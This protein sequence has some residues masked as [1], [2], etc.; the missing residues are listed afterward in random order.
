MME[1]YYRVNYGD[2]MIAGANVEVSNRLTLVRRPGNPNY[3]ANSW[4][5][6]LSFDEFRVNKSASDI[7]GTTLEE[8][9]TMVTE[10]GQLY[11]LTSGLVKALV[12]DD[13]SMVSGQTYMQEVGNSLYFANGVDN[14]KWIQSLFQRV[15]GNNN[16]YPQGS[17]GLAGTYPFGTF[18]IDSNNNIEEM[19]GVAAATITNIAITSKVLTVTL[20]MASPNADTVDYVKGTSFMLW[21]VGTQTWLNG[22]IVTS[23]NSYTHGAGTWTFTAA[24]SHADVVSAVETGWA[25]QIGTTPV[26]A[27]TG[28][29]PTFHT[30]VSNASNNSGAIAPTGNITLDGNILWM[31]RGGQVENW[32]IQAPRTA[33]TVS[34]T[35]ASS[36]GWKASTYYSAPGVIV[37]ANNNIWQ[38]TT[39]GTTG[40]SNTFPA[41]PTVGNTHTDG[42]AVWTCVTTHTSSGQVW[43]AHT[44]Y[45][46]GTY[47]GAYPWPT[48]TPEDGAFLPDWK[49]GK[50]IIATASGTP[51][52]FMLQKNIPTSNINVPISATYGGGTAGHPGWTCQF[53]T[54]SNSVPGGVIDLDY[55][56][57]GTPVR[58]GTLT[59]ETPTTSATG[60]TSLLWDYYNASDIATGPMK[61][62]TLNSAGE[63]NASTH[64]TPWAGMPAPSGGGYTFAQ[65]GKI[66][67]QVD[68]INVTFNILADSSCYF[69][70]EAA[71]G[72]SIVSTSASP[73]GA[74]PVTIESAPA[75]GGSLGTRTLTFWNGYPILAGYNTGNE[76]GS[77]MSITV[78]FPTAG[79]YA[80]EFDF[81]S[82]NETHPR[83]YFMVTAN[84]AQ[85]VPESATTQPWFESAAVSPVW[86]TAAWNLLSASSD[87]YPGVLE[88]SNNAAT[89]TVAANG[90]YGVANGNQLKWYNLGP[91]TDFKWPALTPVTLPSTIIVDKNSNEQTSY[92]TG[93]SGTTQPVWQTTKFSLTADQA[94]LQWICLGSIPPVNNGTGQITATSAQGWLYWIALVNTVDQTVSNVGPVSLGTGPV[95]A[96][97]ILIPAGAGI[98]LTTLDP[99]VDYVAIF[100]ST[101]GGA[102]PLLVPGLGN[103]IWTVPLTQ[104]LQNGYIDTTPD[105]GLDELI[106]GAAAGENT[107]PPTGTVNL[108]YHLNRIWYSV[109]N[110]VWYTSGPTTPSGN[111]NGTN[112]LNYSTVPSQVKR[113]VPTAIGMLV[114]TVS[115]IYIIAGNGTSSNPILP[116]VPYL[117]GIGLAGYNALDI[118]GG[119][120]GFYTTDKQ[121]VIFNPSA[122]LDYA[123]FP[124]G[125]QLRLNNGTPGQSWNPDKV[126]VAWYTNGEDQAW[127]L[128]DGYNGWYK[129]IATPAPETGTSWSPFATING[130]AG[131]I[132][133]IKA[134]EVSPGN[135]KLLIGPGS[136]TD[137]ILTRDLDAT[138][139]SGTT[140]SNGTT[141]PAYGI[142]GSYVLA[143]PGQV[144]KVAFVTV[145]SVLTG[146]PAVLGLLLDEALPYFKGSLDIIKRWVNDPPELPPSKSFY[147]Q[148]FYL[149][150]DP[151]ETAYCSDMQIMIQWPPEAAQN[152][153]QTFTIWGAYE[154]E[155]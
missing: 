99:Q 47:S 141:Y 28:S 48:G 67:I 102:I 11:S 2:V 59:P 24:V 155:N 33:I 94:P 54:G 129:F 132:Q 42:T 89:W 14:K 26:V 144:A 92:E 68:G 124:I 86:S 69:G 140:G 84:G 32:G 62:Y 19:I 43:A 36:T 79:V 111:G 127:F 5:N 21:G 105:T 58:Y 37:D 30:A 83:N 73:G 78:N 118:N 20:N 151:D 7:W 76:Y 44:G 143:L 45:I 134:V 9:F 60:V 46:D 61:N 106:Q 18:F 150:D 22:L 135:H 17:N 116:A 75:L 27:K 29:L 123:G 103:A 39:A 125:D 15:S 81:G 133:A 31:N 109:G 10:P 8:I 74:G 72:A 142:F 49:S 90:V 117:T 137:Q 97:Q 154:I 126:Y 13:S 108:T 153:L 130:G 119:L 82:K 107:P 87:T 131:A 12:F 34:E 1:Q 56:G 98:D 113:L 104:Y 51:C 63:C 4:Q 80:I 38:V 40:S 148:R 114:F 128:G 145:K 77:G 53:F 100:R 71:A 16:S 115:D 138:T 122:G 25:Q 65:Y 91:V 66:R 23:T 3:D 147:S 139:D 35:G 64:T 120:I 52:L 41:S 112:P 101:D 121:F 70:V 96:G 152:E 57:P 85:I 88:N 55:G 146:S 136:V 95:I 110:T 149:S 50:F 93:V 6:V